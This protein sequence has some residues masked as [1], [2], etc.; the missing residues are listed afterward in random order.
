MRH[1][2]AEEKGRRD[3]GRQISQQ[4]AKMAETMFDVVAVNP[5]EQHIASQVHPTGMHEHCGEHTEG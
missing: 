2:Q 5:K 3:T 4:I 1:E